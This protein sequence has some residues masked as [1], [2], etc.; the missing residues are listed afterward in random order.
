MTK[1]NRRVITWTHIESNPNYR[2]DIEKYNHKIY[3]IGCHEFGVRATGK[4]YDYNSGQDYFNADGTH[5]GRRMAA[6]IEQDIVNYPSIKWYLQMI[7]FGWSTVKPVLDNKVVNAEGRL[8]LDQFVYELNKILDLYETDRNGNPL[9]LTGVEMDVE[10]SMTSDYVSQ[11]N[12]INYIRFLEKVKNE[13]IIPRQMK[14]RVNA[15]AMWGVQT[16]YYY[17]FHNYKLFAE[18]TDMNG[19]AT[20]DEIQLMTYDYAWNGS[21]AGASTPIWWFK[22]VG[23]WCVKNFDPNVNPNA[24]LT[25]DN[26][27]FGAA[28][29]G[30]RWGMATQQE[31]KSGSNITYHQLLGWANGQY[32]HYHT[33][34]DPTTGE[35]IY[36]YHNQ[37]YLFQS[38]FQDDESKNEVMYPHVYD[39]FKPKYVTV[40]EIDGGRDSAVVGT[41]NG[42][43]YAATNFK[44]QM[45]I[46]TNV[47]SFANI[48]SSVS[49]KAF[50]VNPKT[51]GLR[52]SDV[53][54]Y[55]LLR[56]YDPI[57]DPNDVNF[58]HLV[59]TVD[60]VDNVFVGYYT[61]DRRYY[62][63]SDGLSCILEDEPEGQIT[64]TVNVP[65]TGTYKLIA[66]TNFSWYSQAK[67]GGYVNGQ[68]QFT[69][70]GDAIPEWYPFFLKGSHWVD[71]G[72]IP[73]NAGSN[74]I[75][76]HGELSDEWTPI[77]GFVVCD[78][79]DQNFSGGELTVNANIQ[80]MLKKDGTPATIPTTLALAAKML[81]RDARPAILWDDEFR[82]YG[83]G[84]EISGV[85]Y[86]RKV[87]QGYLIEGGGTNIGTNAN[88]QAVCYS[89][90]KPVGYTQGFWTQQDDGTG[91]QCLHFDSDEP[92]NAARSAQ[93][94]LSKQWSVNL[95]IEADLQVVSGSQAGI[96]FYAQSEGT[97]ADGYVFRV[98]LQRG[99]RE[100]VFEDYTTGESKVVASQPIGNVEHGTVYTVKALLHNGVGQFFVGGVQAFIQDDSTP[101]SIT[102]TQVTHDGSVDVGN[103]KVTMIRSSGACG[104]YANNVKLYCY[105]LG[106]ATTDRWETMEKFEVSVDG[107]TKE[108]GRINRTGIS[109]DEFGYL[110]YSGLDETSTRDA[111]QFFDEDTTA[112]SLDYEVTVFDWNSWQGAKE[113]KIKLRDAGVWFGELL[114]G[115]KE[116]MSVIW[117]GDAWSFLDV[118]NRAVNDYG[119]KG[120]GLWAMG[121]EDPKVWELIPDVVPKK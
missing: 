60:G 64:Y 41:F 87:Q 66:L 81:R 53:E 89:D 5:T 7:L 91:R 94:V 6:L 49:G 100:L 103:G 110:I 21:A 80:P 46:W 90:P 50:A 34:Q 56:E 75:T 62:P 106:I 67:L 72:Y 116:G 113:L 121:Q 24:K 23:D 82:T 97:V 61:L 25:I 71:L 33:E 101:E 96:R 52:T 28:G 107:T 83:E 45:P 2:N 79:F 74:T 112:V 48:P 9:N 15:H 43:D 76:V 39:M 115:D 93:L 38:A 17:R 99:V 11:G 108:F 22:D 92:Q 73:F 37:E 44:L 68:T 120:I 104:I 31:V 111:T 58:G 59:K 3:S 20:I 10:A 40:K 16:P 105:H 8:P 78:N 109:Y 88:G 77:Y 63:S 19:N 85:T 98:D 65:T 86:Y 117:A 70:G 54:N 1:D 55:P 102:Q 42:N 119:A 118:M 30:H 51:K 29:Y 35:T 12:D 84:N 4:I 69:I 18:S 114:I 36:V 14:M 32:R 26:L 47:R 95:S 57:L 27:Y 13:V